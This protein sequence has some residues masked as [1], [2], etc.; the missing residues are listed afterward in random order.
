MSD[1]SNSQKTRLSV[2]PILLWLSLCLLALYTV[3]R[4]L[5]VTRGISLW[6]LGGTANHKMTPHTAES[7]LFIKTS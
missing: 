3:L 6:L 7:F 4:I 1:S 2:H 5:Y